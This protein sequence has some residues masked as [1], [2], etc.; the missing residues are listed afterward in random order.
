MSDIVKRP[1]AHQISGSFELD[2]RMRPQKMTEVEWLR[3]LARNFADAFPGIKPEDHDAWAIADE[4]ERLE[5]ECQQSMAEIANLRAEIERLRAGL[6]EIAA[7]KSEDLYYA[8]DQPWDNAAAAYAH[9]ILE[10][11]IP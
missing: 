10:G 11:P 9:A 4:I 2:N 6:A 1:P 3:N 5:N 7:M 8:S